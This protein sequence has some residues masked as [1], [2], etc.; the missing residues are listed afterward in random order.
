MDITGFNETKN[1]S[2]EKLD[3]LSKKEKLLRR[4]LTNRCLFSP[5]VFTHMFFWEDLA[6]ADSAYAD[7]ELHTNIRHS[8]FDYTLISDG[9]FYI[10]ANLTGIL[11]F[12]ILRPSAHDIW[13]KTNVYRNGHYR[14]GKQ[15]VNSPIFSDVVNFVVEK[16]SKGENISSKQ[17]KKIHDDLLKNISKVPNSEIYRDKKLDKEIKYE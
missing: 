13:R 8:A 1:L 12:T 10:V 3:V 14:I 4:F 9:G 16:I 2:K 15:Y 5:R 6:S 11:I 7:A 17:N